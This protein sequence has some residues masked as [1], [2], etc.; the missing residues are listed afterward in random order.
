MCL[1]RATAEELGA[2]DHTV[3]EVLMGALL[4]DVGKAAVSD[5]AQPDENESA[6]ER[7]RRI[8]R[9][10]SACVR[11]FE[12]IEFPWKVLPVIRHHHE[13]YDGSG[14]PDGLRGREIPMGARIVAVVDAYLS[15]R[16][17]RGDSSMDL[18]AAMDDLIQ[19]AGDEFDPEVVEAFHRVID[20]R[21][22]GRRSRGDPSVILVDDDDDFR[23][24]MKMQ[25]T[26]E[27]LDVREAEGYERCMEQL[28]R[29]PPDLAIVAIDSDP[30]GAFQLL[31][32]LQQDD[33]L[34]RIPIAFL[35][36][37][38]DRV[39]RIRALRQGVDAFL[40]RD[41]TEDLVAQ[42]Q[43]IL[44]RESVRAE[45]DS[46]RSR[47]GISGRLDSLGLPDIVQTL[48]IG[49][50]TACISLRSDD[51]EGKI[52][53]EN[54]APRHAVTDDLKGDEAFFAMVRWTEGEFVIE[55][56]LR[57][58]TTTLERDAM[59]L[60]MEGLRLMDEASEVRETG[61]TQAAS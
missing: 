7:N 47:R 33:K 32:E 35:S 29:D 26:N 6:D 39:V 20:K 59:F 57:T 5:K 18:D 50:K 40:T 31:Q 4:R 51:R 61:E 14:A 53:F 27:G 37:R 60:V 13:R 41:D 16:S 42:V 28:L 56:G 44:V 2:L 46:R 52:W 9:H 43:S 48:T 24:V 10:V 19:R 54:G 38:A 55:H 11:L 23:R 21:T 8:R 15:I 3:D 12:H 49:M 17:G 45:G 34:C 30:S 1:A 22:A 58:E 36:Q 25:L